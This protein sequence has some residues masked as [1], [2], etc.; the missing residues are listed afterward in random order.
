VLGVYFVP[1]LN[2]WNWAS[3][4][5]AT[6]QVALWVLFGILQMYTNYNFVVQDRT[7]TL[8]QKKETIKRFVSGCEKGLFVNSPYAKNETTR[9]TLN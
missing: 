4:I 5:S 3:F 8:R 2:N 7:S 1:Q 9:L 6:M